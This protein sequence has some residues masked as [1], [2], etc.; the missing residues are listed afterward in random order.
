M[1]CSC[2]FKIVKV[3]LTRLPHVKAHINLAA[4]DITAV[5]ISLI[6][7]RVAFDH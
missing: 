3:A 2:F 7:V 4:D 6:N 5:L 1:T